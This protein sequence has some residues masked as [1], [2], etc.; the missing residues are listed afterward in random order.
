MKKLQLVISHRIFRH[1]VDSY[2]WVEDHFDY[3]S[4]K[5]CIETRTFSAVR[6]EDIGLHFDSDYISQDDLR[7][8]SQWVESLHC[9]SIVD[10]EVINSEPELSSKILKRCNNLKRLEYVLA[11]E[12]YISV[13]PEPLTCW[14]ELTFQLEVLVVHVYDPEESFFNE[15]FK[16]FL[17]NQ[18]NLNKIWISN[19]NFSWEK[20]DTHMKFKVYPILELEWNTPTIEYSTKPLDL[21]YLRHSIDDSYRVPAD[22]NSFENKIRTF[23][24]DESDSTGMKLS[25]LIFKVSIGWQKWVGGDVALSKQ[26]IEDLIAKMPK[27]R[28]LELYT[29]LNLE[30]IQEVISAS[31][32]KFDEIKI[33]TKDGVGTHSFIRRLRS[34]MPFN[35]LNPY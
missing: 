20:I 9:D 12:D 18:K 4:L 8:L 25:R 29:V 7:N 27:L 31:G 21:S 30:E 19:S 17:S 28:V 5:N 35:D 33:H 3:N 11:S 32:R 23:M 14:P 15:P 1:F 13:E 26:F 24:D 6:I 22:I 10:L 34:S 16:Q 2:F